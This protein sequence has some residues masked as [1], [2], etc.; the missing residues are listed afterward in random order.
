VAVSFDNHPDRYV[1]VQGGEFADI[2]VQD[3][4]NGLLVA[5]EAKYLDDWDYQKDVVQNAEKFE[6]VRA[7]LDVKS[8][9][10]C[11]LLPR[12]KWENVIAMQAHP[13][14]NYRKLK[15]HQGNVAV[16]LWESFLELDGVP[17][18]VQSY[19]RSQL[20]HRRLRSSS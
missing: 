16:L 19:V 10:L 17:Q 20:D 13:G 8:A 12:A 1:G 14:S 7:K 4:D 2:L 3:L 11:L 15:E 9:L 6:L 18:Q 5:I